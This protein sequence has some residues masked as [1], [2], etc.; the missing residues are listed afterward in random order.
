MTT[1]YAQKLL[2]DAV[3]SYAVIRKKYE[4]SGHHNPNFWDYC[5]GDVDLLYLHL[6]LT[7]LNDPQFERFRSEGLELTTYMDSGSGPG[8]F[9]PEGSSLNSNSGLS[10]S[11]SIVNNA[12]KTIGAAALYYLK[13]RNA[14]RTESR[15]AQI[16][17]MKSAAATAE[18]T[19]ATAERAAAT[20]ERKRISEDPPTKLKVYREIAAELREMTK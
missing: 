1:K 6:W 18:R 11:G 2:R 10:V 4:F 17:L 19:V 12:K 15:E 9:S 20:A 7:H 14:V 16:N 5:N 8:L 13:G 3:N